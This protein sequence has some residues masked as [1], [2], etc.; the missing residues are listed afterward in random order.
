MSV[1][2]WDRDRGRGA[3]S[4]MIESKCLDCGIIQISHYE[5]PVLFWGKGIKGIIKIGGG[6]SCD[7]E[8]PSFAKPNSNELSSKLKHKL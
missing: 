5:Y 3:G 2:C 4:S 8:R 7:C 6:T 1:G